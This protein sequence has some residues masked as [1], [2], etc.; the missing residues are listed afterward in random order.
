M[1]ENANSAVEENFQI[2]V[3]LHAAG[4]WADPMDPELLPIR[5]VKEGT[6][7]FIYFIL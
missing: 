3:F 5:A 2:A 4:N 7:V 1:H 6:P